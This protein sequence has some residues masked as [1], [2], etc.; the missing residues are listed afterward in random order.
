VKVIFFGDMIV[1]VGTWEGE[2]RFVEVRFIGN[3]MGTFFC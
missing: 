2:E 1:D 3:C